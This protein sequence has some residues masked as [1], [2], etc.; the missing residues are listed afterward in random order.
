M[1]DHIQQEWI[2]LWIE[3]RVLSAP[4]NTALV[5]KLIKLAQT[6]QIGYLK[7]I[8]SHPFA[9]PEDQTQQIGDIPRGARYRVC[10]TVA[11]WNKRVLLDLLVPG[12]TPWDIERRGSRRANGL[13]ERFCSLSI[14]VKDTPPICDV[15]LIIKGR[16]TRGGKEFL[17][18]HGLLGFVQNRSIQTVSSQLYVK[19]YSAFFD[20]YSQL[21]RRLLLLQNMIMF[22]M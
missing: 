16:L 8:A 21:K 6:Q 5:V 15:H 11:L 17:E 20:L 12:E 7:L 19:L 4:V 14:H 13:D 10:M 2:I 9:F 1:L 18:R 3:D 22:H